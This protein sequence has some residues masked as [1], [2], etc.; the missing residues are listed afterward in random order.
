MDR[1]DTVTNIGSFLHNR[2]NCITCWKNLIHVS[3]Q[4]TK[5]NT[6]IKKKNLSN[7]NNKYTNFLERKFQIFW[8]L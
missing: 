1:Q 8:E 2:H 4:N 5:Q 7:L 6:A 3:N